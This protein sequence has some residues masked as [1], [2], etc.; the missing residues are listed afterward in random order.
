MIIVLN[1]LNIWEQPKRIKIPFMKKE[2]IEIR[3]CLLSFCAES[4]V[5]QFAIQIL[6]NYNLAGCFI[7]L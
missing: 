1:S 7:A 3:E 4:L 6:Q 2:Q 5:F